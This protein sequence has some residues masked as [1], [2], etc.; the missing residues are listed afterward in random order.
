MWAHAP[1]VSESVNQFISQGLLNDPKVRPMLEPLPGIMEAVFQSRKSLFRDKLD[2]K[3]RKE[4]QAKAEAEAKSESESESGVDDDN[5]PEAHLTGR[6]P[7][8]VVTAL[9]E[10]NLSWNDIEDIEGIW[11]KF[12]GDRTSLGNEI[13]DL[14]FDKQVTRRIENK[15]LLE[16]VSLG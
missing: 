1:D 2:K 11:L 8:R 9:Q 16:L 7:M 5:E 3:S 10:L 6:L 14:G 15:L 4:A 13:A 12:S